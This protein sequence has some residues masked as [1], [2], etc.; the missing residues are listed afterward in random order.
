[1]NPGSSEKRH[2]FDNPRNVHRVLRSLYTICAAFILIDVIDFVLHKFAGF[3]ALR[4]AE[5]PLDWLPGY[6]GIYGFVACAL[7][8]LIAKE[9]RKILI[10]DEDYYDR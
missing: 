2:L 3:S 7:L 6:Y 10:R 8:V 4:H 9:L 1:M 5:G